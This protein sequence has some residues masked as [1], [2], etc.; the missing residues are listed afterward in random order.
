MFVGPDFSGHHFIASDDHDIWESKTCSSQTLSQDPSK[1]WF[2]DIQ[3]PCKT[4]YGDLRRNYTNLHRNYANLRR[5]LGMW[6]LPL[7]TFF[8]EK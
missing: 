7:F 1:V 4:E 5:H 2:Q 6:F 8:F 3:N